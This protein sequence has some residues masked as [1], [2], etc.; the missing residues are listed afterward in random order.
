MS[1]KVNES[2][3]WSPADLREAVFSA[4]VDWPKV[5]MQT[6]RERPSTRTLGDAYRVFFSQKS[7]RLIIALFIVALSIRVI[8]GA[9]FRPV[10]IVFPLVVGALW[11]LLEWTAHK[12]VLHQ[13]PKR[14]RGQ[15]WLPY[16][17][18]RH[19]AHHLNPSDIGLIFLPLRVVVGAYIAFGLLSWLLSAFSLAI[20]ASFLMTMSVAA[21][22]YEWTHFITHVDYR[23]KTK[24]VRQI[25]QRHRLHHYKHEENW[26]AFTVPA[27]DDWLNTA[28]DVQQIETSTSCR[29]IHREL[30]STSS[31]AP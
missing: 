24:Y 5:E 13:R 31:S 4:D 3:S 15:L 29:T 2:S 25:W 12:Y 16:P 10:E 30:A 11:P 18:L 26:F 23:P 14:R 17:A 22:I 1:F 27:V 7:P 20:M 6:K 21:L 28:P 8:S 9:A 19:V